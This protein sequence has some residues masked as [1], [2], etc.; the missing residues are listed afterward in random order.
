MRRLARNEL[1][2]SSKKKKKKRKKMKLTFN[3]RII[4]KKLLKLNHSI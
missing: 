3:I 4:K 1:V 2:I